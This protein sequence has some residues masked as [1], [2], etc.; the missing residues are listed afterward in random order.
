MHGGLRLFDE[1][2][3]IGVRYTKV[4]PTQARTI[5]DNGNLEELTDPYQIVDLYGA[6]RASENVTLRFAVNNLTDVYYVPATGGAWILRRPGGRPRRQSTSG[7]DEGALART[8][9][10]GI[11]AKFVAPGR[12]I[13]RGD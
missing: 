1:K 8:V 10:V 13:G 3:S 6:F 5:D 4:S 2:L 9:T 11:W 7:F 12:K